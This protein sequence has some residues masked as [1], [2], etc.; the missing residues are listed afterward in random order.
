[1]AL[2]KAIDRVYA[3]KGRLAIL[4]GIDPS[5]PDEI[6]ICRVEEEFKA[7]SGHTVKK[8]RKKNHASQIYSPRRTNP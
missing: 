5:L 6:F 3:I 4:L 7:L 8:T 1:M 2:P